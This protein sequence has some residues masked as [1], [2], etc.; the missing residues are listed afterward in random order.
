[1]SI[2]AKLRA[3]ASAPEKDVTELVNRLAAEARVKPPRFPNLITPDG[4]EVVLDVEVEGFRCILLRLQPLGHSEDPMLSPRE[5][6]IARMV[7]KGYANKTIATVLDISSWTV[8][9]YLRRIFA[10]L[11]VS[12]RAA[13]VARLLEQGTMNRNLQSEPLD[14]ATPTVR[15]QTRRP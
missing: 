11:G 13:M 6:E 7:A 3:A 12:S 1:V 14:R 8:G 15:P 10:K 2:D 9:S 5:H 4:Q